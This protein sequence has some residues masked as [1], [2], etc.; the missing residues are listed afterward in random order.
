M[1]QRTDAQGNLRENDEIS[2][3]L[4]RIEAAKL[5]LGLTVPEGLE[6]LLRL[7]YAMGLE[8]APQVGAEAR[9]R[10]LEQVAGPS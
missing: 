9:G 3:A 2:F 10:L 4:G 5:S 1:A 8:D 7:V 6:G